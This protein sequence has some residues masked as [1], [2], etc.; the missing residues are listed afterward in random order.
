MSRIPG[1][2]AR[3]SFCPF[4]DVGAVVT[5]G[6]VEQAA[7]EHT[8]LGLAGE[9]HLRALVTGFALQAAQLSLGDG[10]RRVAVVLSFCE[11]VPADR[12]ELARGRAE[13]DLGAAADLE[14]GVE[15]AQRAGRADSGVCR[16]DQQPA[17]VCLA[18]AGDVAV[19]GF[20]LT[21]WRTRGSR[22][23]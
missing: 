15:G 13:R 10:R 19:A 9:A 16:L 5:L 12:R 21:D 1:G 22:P 3:A 2:G 7:L 4:G 18:L 23:R 17:R 11:Q 20:A 8:F 6:L 14:P